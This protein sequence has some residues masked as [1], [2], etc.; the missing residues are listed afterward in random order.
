M[1]NKISDQDVLNLLTSLKNTE[2]NYPSDMIQSRRDTY[3][4]QAAAMAVLVGA[5]AGGNG[6]SA[7]G[8]AQ[9]TTSG[10]VTGGS[11]SIGKLLE[12]ALVV[13]LVIE[14]GIATYVYRDKIAEFFNSTFSSKIEQTANPPDDSSPGILAS[15]EASSVTPNGTST[16]TVTETPTP[17]V[18]SIPAA[19][20][21]NNIENNSANGESVNITSTPDPNGD[22]GL[23]IGQTKQPT[24]DTD[25]DKKNDNDS[26]NNKDVKDPD[27]KDKEK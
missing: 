7:S 15:E 9:T 10:A 18:T 20:D 19:G 17:S 26:N 12:T 2:N 5:G 24:K 1:K 8:N 3:M 4:K 6:A 23:H 22:S 14:A 27:D 25:P 21:N 13:A 16:I 11:V